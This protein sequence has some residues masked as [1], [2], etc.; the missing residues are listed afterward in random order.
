MLL[1]GIAP[2]RIN[3][4]HNRNK[5]L[6]MLGYRV[7]YFVCPTRNIDNRSLILLYITYPFCGIFA[8]NRQNSYPFICLKLKRRGRVG[9]CSDNDCLYFICFGKMTNTLIKIICQSATKEN[10]GHLWLCYIC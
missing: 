1:K 10:G 3:A 8:G 7:I 5:G 2:L 6:K 9:R 4:H